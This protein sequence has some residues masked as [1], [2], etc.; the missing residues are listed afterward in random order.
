MNSL[1]IKPHLT[2]KTMAATAHNRFAFLVSPKANKNQIKEAVQAAFG[3]HVTGITT[4]TKKS[5]THRHAR[6]G[7]TITSSRKKIAYVQLKSG[8]TITL[9]ETKSE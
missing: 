9:F 7:K 2:E 4:R 3:V 5:L 8:E 1:I 6:T